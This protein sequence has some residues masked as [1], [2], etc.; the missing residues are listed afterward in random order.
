MTHMYNIYTK[1][2]TNDKI[3]FSH[4]LTVKQ[5]N[6]SSS[7]PGLYKVWPWFHKDS[8]GLSIVICQSHR[9]HQLELRLWVCGFLGLAFTK[10]TKN[11]IGP[12]CFPSCWKLL[13]FLSLLF[14]SKSR[15]SS[16]LIQ[17]IQIWSTLNGKVKFGPG[18]FQWHYMPWNRICQLIWIL[19]KGFTYVKFQEATL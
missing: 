15:S 5:R 7:V 3:W 11:G 12:G 19:S 17:F 18:N 4:C 16:P 14:F 10:L 6:I 13:S 9:I 1:W 8:T 2:K